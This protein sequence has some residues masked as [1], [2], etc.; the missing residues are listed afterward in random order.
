MVH[1]LSCSTRGIFLDQGLNLCLLHWQADSLPL[2][3]QRS[4]DDSTI[5]RKSNLLNHWGEPMSLHLFIQHANPFLILEKSSNNTIIVLC[6]VAQSC[7]TLCNPTDCSPTGSS[8]HGILQATILEWV[9][10]PSSRGSSQPRDRTQVSH[11][12][13]R[14]FTV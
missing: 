3:H 4:L 14:F 1:R 8:I 10:M 6:L 11:I 12:A 13:R 5:K 2:S 9:A 7:L